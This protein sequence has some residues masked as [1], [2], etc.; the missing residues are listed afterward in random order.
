MRR[1]AAVLVE[2][3]RMAATSIGEYELT[4]AREFI[5]GDIELSMEDPHALAAW[6]AREHLLESERLSPEEV[7]AKYEQVSGSDVARVAAR[8]LSDDWA[9][10]A[11]AGP[12]DEDHPLPVTLAGKP[13]AE[14]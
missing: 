2:L 3:G 9:I 11:A 13:E 1:W 5:K 4:R 8:V 10:A 12:L 6:Y 14:A 7:V